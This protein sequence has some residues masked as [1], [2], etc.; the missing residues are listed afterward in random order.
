MV[1]ILHL[2]DLAVAL[3]AGAGLTAALACAGSPRLALRFALSL[4]G[5]ILLVGATKVAYLGWGTAIAPL[6]YKALSGHAAVAATVYP[7]MAW[8]LLRPLGMRYALLGVGG[9]ALLAAAVALVLVMHEQHTQAEAA[10][11]WLVGLS[12]SLANIGRGYAP[13]ASRWLPALSC[14]IPAALLC[15]WAVQQAHIGYWLV[16]L[17]LLFSG[18]P[19]P[20]SWNNDA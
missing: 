18:A 10:G 9:A 1:R 13:A 8:V 12:A 5:V 19:V 4:A 6:D 20:H 14:A 3:P 7:F 2:G 15:A 11:G 17:A 16:R